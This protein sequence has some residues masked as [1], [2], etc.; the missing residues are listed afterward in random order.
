MHRSF[1]LLVIASATHGA[2][3]YITVL[4]YVGSD[5]FDVFKSIRYLTKKHFIK[6]EWAE[7]LY[8][9]SRECREAEH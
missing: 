4:V 1:Q 3:L 6:A 7:V 9:G 5:S 2:L 8:E